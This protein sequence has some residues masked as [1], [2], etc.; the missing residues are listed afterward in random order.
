MFPNSS[1]ATPCFSTGRYSADIGRSL[2]SIE[3]DL[4]RQLNNEG[5]A[6]SCS[7]L[8]DKVCDLSSPESVENLSTEVERRS[9]TNGPLNKSVKPHLDNDRDK[10]REIHHQMHKDDDC[11]RQ[12]KREG[13]KRRSNE[14]ITTSDIRVSGTKDYT[15]P[16]GNKEQCSV[17]VEREAAEAAVEGD[18]HEGNEGSD[19]VVVSVSDLL[20]PEAQL[21]TQEI[22]L[23][24]TS[25]CSTKST[26]STVCR[27][28]EAA[29]PFDKQIFFPNTDSH[30][31]SDTKQIFS[32][33]ECKS[34]STRKLATE[35]PHQ[36]LRHESHVAECLLERKT[37]SM[38]LTVHVPRRH[39]LSEV[40]SI[41][42]H[43]ST[44]LP[45]RPRSALCEGQGMTQKTDS[46]FKRPQSAMQISKK[47]G[48]EQKKSCS[49]IFIDLSKLTN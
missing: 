11:E 5:T 20:S 38:Q 22:L 33:T 4:D 15:K 28:N 34:S 6:S 18:D 46:S 47:P 13:E 48:A 39:K 32:H 16:V 26:E 21:L 3:N 7:L 10:Q 23:E 17:V 27:Y 12:E 1:T 49:T 40:V 45:T 19:S 31:Y 36:Q 42:R 30:Q 29:R 2:I 25:M 37:D 44:A 35:H 24:T 9:V 14:D 41:S 43:N 8:S